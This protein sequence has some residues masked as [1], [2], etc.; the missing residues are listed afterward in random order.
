[1]DAQSDWNPKS[2][3]Y[4]KVCEAIAEADCSL[5]QAVAEVSLALAALISSA[6]T[7]DRARLAIAQTVADQILTWVRMGVE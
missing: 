2:Q 7:T 6:P 5:L 4:P 1:M 3:L